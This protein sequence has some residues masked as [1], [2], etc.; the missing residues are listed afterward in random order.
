[1]A[2][3]RVEHAHRVAAAVEAAAGRQVV[4]A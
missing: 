1:V 3:E 4:E 2:V